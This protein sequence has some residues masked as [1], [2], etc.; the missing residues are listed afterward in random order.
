MESQSDERTAN[1]REHG[2]VVPI[3]TTGGRLMCPLDHRFLAKGLPD[4]ALVGSESALS[5]S[6]SAP[7]FSDI[8]R[9][10]DR[11]DLVRRLDARGDLE[12]LERAI[13]QSPPEVQTVVEYHRAR[14]IV[15]HCR[16]EF[17]R[18][19]T[20]EL[21]DLIARARAGLVRTE[22]VPSLYQ[23]WHYWSNEA[24][25]W[26]DA[27]AASEAQTATSQERKRALDLECASLAERAEQARQLQAAL[28]ENREL[29][30]E[31]ARLS[32]R[33][34]REE[35]LRQTSEQQLRGT[36]EENFRLERLVRD[37]THRAQSLQAQLEEVIDHRRMFAQELLR[38][39]GRPIDLRDWSDL[40][41]VGSALSTTWMYHTQTVCL[42]QAE[43]ARKAMETLP[44]EIMRRMLG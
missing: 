6:S 17:P 15:A 42:E 2:N 20:E 34:S 12:A 37:W 21:V 3:V 38:R 36:R 19:D 9:A 29:H 1:C 39:D 4:V 26:R 40:Q 10:R 32:M 22:G 33:V 27:A 13:A 7:Y 24:K 30:A 5:L 31:N 25:R 43:R 18:L 8:G 16:E 23:D 14:V 44:Y 11:D 35:G 41:A 28:R